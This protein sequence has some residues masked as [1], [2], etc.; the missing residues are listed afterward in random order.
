MQTALRLPTR[1]PG[2]DSLAVFQGIPPPGV[3]GCLYDLFTDV[4][5]DP[6]L[7]TSFFIAGATENLSCIFARSR[8]SLVDFRLNGLSDPMSLHSVDCQRSATQIFP[9]G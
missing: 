6:L 4:V 8:L 1:S 3:F 2:S 5:V 9:C 7:K